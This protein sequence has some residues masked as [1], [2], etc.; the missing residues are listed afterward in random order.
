M[1]TGQKKFH[2]ARLLASRAD[3]KRLLGQLDDATMARL[4]GMR[5]SL[6]ELL[7]VETWLAAQGDES[8]RPEHPL[9]PRIMA[10]LD[11]ILGCDGDE[12]SSINGSE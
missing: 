5:P 8:A 12:L 11:V 3:I 1:S 2:R 6:S 10:F 4:E 7:G 9:T